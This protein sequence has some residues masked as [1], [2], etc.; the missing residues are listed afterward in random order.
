MPETPANRLAHETS[1]YLREHAHQPVDWHPWGGEALDRAAREGRPIFLS[2][3]YSACHWCHVMARE[4]FSDP[5]IARRLN[6]YFIS[7]KVDREE[8]PDIDALYMKA[9]VALNGQGGWPLNLFLTPDQKPYLGGTYYPPEGDGHRTGF[10]ALVQTAHEM[11]QQ[12][13][14]TLSERTGKVLL[15]LA[16]GPTTSRPCGIEQIQAAVE[17]LSG[18]YD[19]EYGGFGSGMK[20]PEPMVYTLLLRHWLRTES[21][22]VLTMLD[23]TLT[24]MAEGGL[25]DQLGGGFH[26]Y[27]TDRRFLVP[28]FEKMLDDNALLA[29]LYI[30]MFQATKQAIYLETF[31]GVA[32]FVLRELTSPEGLFHS[33]Q[34]AETEAGEGAFY[35]WELKEVLNLLGPKH[36]KVFART[37]G[38]TTTGHFN[39]KNVLHRSDSMEKIAEEEGMPIFEVHH[40]LKK[41]RETLLEARQKRPRPMRDDKIITAWNGMMITALAAGFSVTRERKYLDA[42]LQASGA[43]WQSRFGEG[44]LARL[45]AEGN[46]TPGFLDDHAFLLEALIGLYEATGDV[47]WIE[48]SG[49]LADLMIGEFWDAKESGFFMTGASQPAL[50]ARLK[51]PA[52]EA[53]PSANAVA[54]LSLA[55]L[56]HFTCS[57]RYRQKA[58]DALKAFAP[59]IAENPAAHAGL[60]AAIDFLNGPVSEFV[61]AGPRE[62]AAFEEMMKTLHQDFRPNKVVAWNEGDEPAVAAGKRAPAGEAALFVC[63]KG[64]CYPPVTSAQGLL[65]VLERPPEIR[66][67]IFDEEKKATEIRSR[68]EANFLKA[69]GEIFKHSGF[70]SR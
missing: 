35:L 16:P 70:D 69:M 2:I 42:A 61:F 38:L 31:E 1:P 68:E 53:G 45:A 64:T 41:G 40:I 17:W 34:S 29:K 33:S 9:L 58:D 48:R 36:A 13:G 52:D 11:F 18:R 59:L 12:G 56:A 24:A 67:N 30:D 23:K 47:Q 7:I 50:I 19:A 5:E 37:Y 22:D 15:A 20:F 51:N 25:Y 32:E 66:L 21:G 46:R 63:Q 10:A 62:G 54:A 60:L 4:S 55:R 6:E 65:K 39:R 8:R 44:G 28:H 49:Q 27:S 3:G 26:R 57:T 43:L 14:A